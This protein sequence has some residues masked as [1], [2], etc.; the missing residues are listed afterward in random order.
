MKK[1]IIEEYNDAGKLTKRTTVEEFSEKSIDTYSPI[2]TS[3]AIRLDKNRLLDG[4]IT[5][6]AS[7]CPEFNPKGV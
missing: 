4:T 3:G 2:N 7:G 1:T 5:C 6:N